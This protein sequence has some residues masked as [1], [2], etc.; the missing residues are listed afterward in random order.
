MPEGI[1]ILTSEASLDTVSVTLEALRVGPRQMTMAVFRQLPIVH[2]MRAADVDPRLVFWGK[3][4]YPIKNQG[5]VWAVVEKDGHL[6]R[7][8]L[9]GFRLRWEAAAKLKPIARKFEQAE[10]DVEDIMKHPLH[11][12]DGSVSDWWVQAVEQKKQRAEEVEL[13]YWPLRVNADREVEFNQRGMEAHNTLSNSLK[14][15]FIAI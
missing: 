3:V 6:Y 8:Q 4:R 11:H 7:G 5:D 1:Q 13:E 9:D 14:Q 10:L 12:V 2:V 15:L